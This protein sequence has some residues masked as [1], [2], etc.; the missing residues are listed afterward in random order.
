MGNA[1]LLPAVVE[2][3]CDPSPPP[4]PQQ[5]SRVG[6]R[7]SLVMWPVE[8][9]V[10]AWPWGKWGTSKIAV[11][12]LTGFLVCPSLKL[13]NKFFGVLGWVLLVISFQLL[14]Q[15][16]DIVNHASYKL[17]AP[18]PCTCVIS[19]VRVFP[20]CTAESRG[21]E[22]NFMNVQFIK[23]S[24]HNL[25]SSQTWGFC[26]YFLNHRERVMVFYQVFLLSPL[27]CTVTEP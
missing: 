6:T 7:W 19:V 20:A 25:E 9:S 27:Q 15:Q 13:S 22:A 10:L 12:Y 1:M 8:M 16:V 21:P 23:V 17:N 24:G 2:G 5:G 4:L 26:M 11:L 3:G 18:L 14:H